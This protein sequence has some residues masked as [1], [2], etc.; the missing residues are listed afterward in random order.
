[1]VTGKLGG[2]LETMTSY[3]FLSNL[4][5]VV[6]VPVVFPLIDQDVDISFWAAFG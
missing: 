2:D 5:T 4:V 6:A 3:V 1:M